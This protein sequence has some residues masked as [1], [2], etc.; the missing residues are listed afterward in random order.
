VP[1]LSDE[2]QELLEALWLRLGEGAAVSLPLA[3]AHALDADGAILDLL[4]L[5]LASTSDGTFRLTPLGR[6]E[7]LAAVRR[8]R[9]AE[10]LLADVLDVGGPAMDEAAC[11]FEH[12]L[13][14]GVE[15]A[16]CTLLGHPRVCPH[17]KPIPEGE[18]CRKQRQV[19]P[20]AVAPLCDVRPGEGGRIAYVHAPAARQLQKLMA[21]GVLP[22]R[23]IKLLQ[24]FPS[25]VFQ[26]GHSQFAVDEETAR[27]IYVRLQER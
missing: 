13:T 19:V 10:R 1:K 4:D 24:R 17:G 7:A 27:T 11:G 21:M 23:D 5:G 2:A 8:H 15:Q 22:G 16:I 14:P 9:L 26:V 25:Y 18:C 6:A 3:E 12:S 20:R